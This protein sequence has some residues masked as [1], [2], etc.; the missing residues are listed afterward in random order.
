MLYCDRCGV[1]NQDNAKYC[2]ECGAFLGESLK[3]EQNP[4]DFQE[5][6]EVT[7]DVA[8]NVNVP[9]HKK[10]KRIFKSKKHLLWLIPAAVIFISVSVFG[11]LKIVQNYQKYHAIEIES[12]IMPDNYISDYYTVSTTKAEIQ[13]KGLLKKD[14]KYITFS[15]SVLNAVGDII[16]TYSP[17]ITGPLQQ[18]KSYTYKFIVS[19]LEPMIERVDSTKLTEIEIVYMNGSKIVL[20]EKVIDKLLP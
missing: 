15:V 8:D 4:C 2:N 14:I 17:K 16:E 3:P 9:A 18:N 6:M 1:P 7:S 11:I 10:I 19:F 13:F 12:C 20:D 5:N